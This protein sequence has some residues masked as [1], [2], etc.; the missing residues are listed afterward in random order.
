MTTPIVGL[1]ARPGGEGAEVHRCFPLVLLVLLVLL[2]RGVMWWGRKRRRKFRGG[3]MRARV[4]LVLAQAVASEANMRRTNRNE[5]WMKPREG[6]GR[7][8]HPLGLGLL[9]GEVWGDSVSFQENVGRV[10]QAFF[11][12]PAM[13]L[14]ANK[15]QRTS[16][17]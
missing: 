17:A 10:S 16:R 6:D 12:S 7:V 2:I 1:V 4:E 11:A 14:S 13:L 15:P 5:T 3:G 8:L 9:R